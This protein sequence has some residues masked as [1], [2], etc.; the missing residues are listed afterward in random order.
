MTPL[1]RLKL[2]GSG[3]RGLG[4]FLLALAARFGCGMILD[5]TENVALL[6]DEEIFAVD[7]HF[8]TGPFAE[9]NAITCLNVESDDLAFLVTGAGAYRNDFALLG[10]FLGRIWNNDSALRALFLF[11]T[12]HHYAVMQRPKFHGLSS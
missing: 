9:E 4:G 12:A 11:E 5:D 8:S 6:H 1:I 10:L 3:S 2:E 7:L